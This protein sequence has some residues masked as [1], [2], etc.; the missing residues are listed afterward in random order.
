[1]P[2]D[3]AKKHR[4]AHSSIPLPCL[5]MS[6]VDESCFGVNTLANWVFFSSY[7]WWLHSTLGSPMRLCPPSGIGALF[8]PAPK[9]QRKPRFQKSKNPSV[10]TEYISTFN[11]QHLSAIRRQSLSN[12]I[13]IRC[14]SRP[15]WSVSGSTLPLSLC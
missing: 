5:Y 11:L 14:Q 12:S 10:R 1:M 9:A 7:W 2:F 13:W 3:E 15:L 6:L 8:S 4:E